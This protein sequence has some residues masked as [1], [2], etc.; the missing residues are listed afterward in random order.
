MANF[1]TTGPPPGSE[2]LGINL[3]GPGLNL[4]PF[5]SELAFDETML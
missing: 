4:E 1:M 2:G 3:A 5:D